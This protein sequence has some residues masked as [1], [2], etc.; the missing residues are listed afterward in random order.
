MQKQRNDK[1]HRN[2]LPIKAGSLSV[3][4]K[5]ISIPLHL[6]NDVEKKLEELKA[7]YVEKVNNMDEDFVS[8]VVITVKNDK[9]GKRALHSRKLNGSWL[10]T[11]AVYAEHGIILN[12]ISV[13][14]TRDQTEQYNYIFQKLI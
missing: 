7:S 14:N 1:R 10:K 4:E 2:K 13:E 11:K 8:A 3:E 9:S 12:Q 5:P 6:Q